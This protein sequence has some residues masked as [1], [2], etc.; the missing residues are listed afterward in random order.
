MAVGPLVPHFA[1]ARGPG[2]GAG[3]GCAEAGGLALARDP[4]GVVPLYHGRTASG[5]LCFAS[6][7]KALLEVT[8]DVNSLPPGHVLEHGRSAAAI[9][10]LTGPRIAWPAAA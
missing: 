3:P 6:E 7:V 9:E 2:G 10:L 5:D 4:I 1:C 8:D